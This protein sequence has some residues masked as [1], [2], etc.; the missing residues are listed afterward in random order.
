MQELSSG[1]QTR[2]GAQRDSRFNEGLNSRQFQETP[3]GYG[4]LF[5]TAMDMAVFGQMFLNGGRYGDKRI[6]SRPTV[7][8]MTR[9]QIP[10]IGLDWFGTYIP[11][12]S[13]GYGWGV[14]SNMKWKYF[15]K[16][17]FTKMFRPPRRLGGVGLG[18]RSRS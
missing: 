14:A 17:S 7:S 13:W 9:N 16:P 1:R 8:E 4:G 6:L 5:S 3:Y 15:G 18:S 12:A 11:E 10:G 2:P